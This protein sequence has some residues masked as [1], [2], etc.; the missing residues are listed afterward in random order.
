MG[1]VGNALSRIRGRWWVWVAGGVSWGLLCVGVRIY[2]YHVSQQKAQL[3]SQRNQ[4]VARVQAAEAALSEV[5]QLEQ[6]EKRAYSLGFVKLGASQI[7][8]VPEDQGTGLLARLLGGRAAPPPPEVYEPPPEPAGT[9]RKPK[10]KKRK[11]G[12]KRGTRR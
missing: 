12:S 5:R 6:M 11:P 9:A 10:A 4:L 1:R 8:I 7:V 2:A 3:V